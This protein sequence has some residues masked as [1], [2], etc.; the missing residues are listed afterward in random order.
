M[1]RRNN[2]MMQNK[3]TK[4]IKL[5]D[6]K[7]E[8]RRCNNMEKVLLF[9]DEQKIFEVTN[10]VLKE[11]YEFVWCTYAG[12]NEN[13][14]TKADI[15]IMHFDEQMTK[16]GTFW[17]IVKVKGRLGHS[18]P[19]LAIIEGGTPQD[20]YAALKAGAYD[21]LETVENVREYKKKIKDIFLWSWYIKKYGLGGGLV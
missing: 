3:I 9:S 11:E 7:D 16:E 12:L 8:C 21:Y 5:K 15:V 2:Y 17:Q 18:I 1:N 10:K 4:E 6:T 14:Y 20:I 13:R 19:I